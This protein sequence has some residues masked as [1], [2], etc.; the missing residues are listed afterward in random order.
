MQK[1]LYVGNINFKATEADLEELFS[2]AGEVLYSKLIRDHETGKLRGF[3]FLEM[4]T[5]QEA[6]K[7]ITLFN[8]QS[9]M[10]RALVVNMAKSRPQ[11]AGR[12]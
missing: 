4:S 11:R 7:A 2:Q 9:F 6:E 8:G 3:G 1:R 10:E 12:F 5:E